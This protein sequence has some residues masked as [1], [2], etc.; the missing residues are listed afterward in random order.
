MEDSNICFD[1][2]EIIRQGY[3]VLKPFCHKMDVDYRNQLEFIKLDFILRDHIVKRRA[4]SRDN[5]SYVML[6]LNLEGFFR[7]IYMMPPYIIDLKHRSNVIKII[8]LIHE[9]Y[10]RTS[11]NYSVPVLYETRPSIQILCSQIVAFIKE[12]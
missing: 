3:C 2:E 7:W 10:N 11:P 9:Y 4:Y 1:F 8:R 5:K 6:T 12:S